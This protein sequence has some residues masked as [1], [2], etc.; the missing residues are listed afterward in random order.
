MVPCPGKIPPSGVRERRGESGVAP[1]LEFACRRFEFVRRDA[2]RRSAGTALGIGE[3]L[4]PKRGAALPAATASGSGAPA[5]SA[6][7]GPRPRRSGRDKRSGLFHRLPRLPAESRHWFQ[8]PESNPSRR[9]R[10]RF[11]SPDPTRKQFA[12]WRSR[13]SAAPRLSMNC[14][15][16]K[17]YKRGGERQAHTGTT[18]HSISLR[19]P[20]LTCDVHAAQVLPLGD[21]E[22][23]RMISGMYE[24]PAPTPC[25]YHRRAMLFVGYERVKSRSKWHWEQPDP[26]RRRVLQTPVTGKRQAAHPRIFFAARETFGLLVDTLL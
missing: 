9:P 24:R 11:R 12:R 18:M 5:V 15:R 19:F 21:F 20:P 4:G 6:S 14:A 16:S 26:L 23:L 13:N 25:V 1:F 7:R 3:S 10:C 22:V 8:R 2:P 17:K